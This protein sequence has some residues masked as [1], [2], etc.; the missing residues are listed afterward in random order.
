MQAQVRIGASRQFALTNAVLIYGDGS[1]SCAPLHDV[2][3][4]HAGAPHFGPGPA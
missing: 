3:T 2:I 4:E 1:T